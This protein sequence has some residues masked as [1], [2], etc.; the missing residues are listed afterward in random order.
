MSPYIDIGSRYSPSDSQSYQVYPLG[1]MKT[2]FPNI[3]CAFEMQPVHLMVLNILILLLQIHPFLFSHLRGIY[4]QADFL[5]TPAGNLY[6]LIHLGSIPG[7]FDER[8][9][10][11]IHM[12]HYFWNFKMDNISFSQNFADK[13]ADFRRFLQSLIFLISATLRLICVTLRKINH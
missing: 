2:S 7:R 9:L 10:A 1:T 12:R 4:Y 3:L 6:F 8:R 11:A 13:D 5:R